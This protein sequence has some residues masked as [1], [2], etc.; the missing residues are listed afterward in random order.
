MPAPD[1]TQPYD[2]WFLNF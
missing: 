1:K 2:R